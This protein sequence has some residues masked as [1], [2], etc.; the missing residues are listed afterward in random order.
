MLCPTCDANLVCASCRN[1][2]VDPTPTAI[3][4]EEP[5]LDEDGNDVFDEDDEDDDDD[6]D[7]GDAVSLAVGFDE[8]TGLVILN[9]GKPT[10]WLALSPENAE[11]M[12][13]L[14]LEN[15]KASRES[16]MS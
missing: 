15:A 6:E 13:N 7:E 9:F 12:A 1:P 4:S 16:Q 11:D 8:D 10:A 14:I 2:L 3:S 5:L